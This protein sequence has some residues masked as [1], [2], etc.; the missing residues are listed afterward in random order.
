M[1]RVIPAAWCPAGDLARIV[2]HWTAGGYV[3]SATD[4]EHYHFLL[5]DGG[6]PVRGEHS[7]R[8][9]LSTRD[10]DYCAHV[11]GL[12]TGSIGIAVC[13]MLSARRLP[14]G[15]DWGPYPVTK[16]QWNN[17]IRA[18]ADLCAAYDIAPE[19]RTLL[20]HCEVE[21]TLGVPQPGKWDIAC[22][23][24]PLLQGYRTPGEELRGRV[25]QLLRG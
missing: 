6:A 19:P 21:R 5:Q 16:Q 18:C 7:V 20:M 4:T 14:W 13:A 9:N 12:N 11:R 23:R 17:L 8:D 24:D 25:A 22:L 3:A 2:V 10:G 15:V 1:P